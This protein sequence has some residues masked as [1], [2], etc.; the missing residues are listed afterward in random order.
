MP[1][2][3]R[4]HKKRFM[5]RFENLLMM[6]AG[7]DHETI[8]KISPYNALGYGFLVLALIYACITLWKTVKYERK[9][10]TNNLKNTTGLLHELAGYL[11]NEGTVEKLL[12]S[13]DIQ[14]KADL[15][16]IKETLNSL[17]NSNS[18]S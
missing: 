11:Q 17:K 14:V 13:H 4:T 10:N 15:Q 6:Q 16:Q 7:V 12:N 3:L 2:F 8:L 5:L 18:N 9:E 1:P